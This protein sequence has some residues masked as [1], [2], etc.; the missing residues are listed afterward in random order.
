LLGFLSRLDDF[1]ETR[2][3]E[4]FLFR[5][6]SNKLIDHLRRQGREPIQKM[7][8]PHEMPEAQFDS[9]P[10]VSSIARGKERVELEELALVSAL[11]EVIRDAQEREDYVRIMVLELLWVKGW[12]NKQVATCLGVAEQQVANIQF[13][14][15]RK[16]QE[17]LRVRGLNPDHFPELCDERE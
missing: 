2:P 8:K 16:M 11:A 9:Q 12:R 10:G 3:I 7:P 14:S 15:K 6:A 4:A 13:Q 17:H 5:I 1:D